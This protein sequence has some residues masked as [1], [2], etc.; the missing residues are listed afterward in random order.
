MGMR[1]VAHSGTALENMRRIRH[2]TRGVT[3]G[4]LGIHRKAKLTLVANDLSGPG[5]S[6][7]DLGRSGP[8]GKR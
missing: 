2:D 6:E 7:N 4:P 8:P 1:S 5:Q 3:G